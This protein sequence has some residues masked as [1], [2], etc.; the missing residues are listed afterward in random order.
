MAKVNAI[1][2]RPVRI[3][4]VI[5]PKSKRSVEVEE[6]ALASKYMQLLI[7]QGSIV[8]PKKPEPAAPAKASAK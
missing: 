2:N 4:K 8:V 3:G 1:F 7:A 6:S 5:Y